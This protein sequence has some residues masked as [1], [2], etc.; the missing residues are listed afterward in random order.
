M[1]ILEREKAEM[2]G[3]AT[4]QNYPL[5]I[6]LALVA[7]LI[8]AIAWGIVGMFGWIIGW[9]GFLIAFLAS[10][11]YDFAKVKTNMVTMGPLGEFP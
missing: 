2:Q 11:F 7:A 6:V 5:A 10:K 8:G 1:D 4:G 9:A 3:K